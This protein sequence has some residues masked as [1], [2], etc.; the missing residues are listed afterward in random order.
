MNVQ[1]A[2]A[3]P[4]AE[5]L[6]KYGHEPVQRR[7]GDL[8]YRSPFR[9][10]E[11]ASFVVSTQ[12]NVWF[13]HGEGK[14]GTVID[15]IARL[16]NETSVAKVLALVSEMVE[17]IVPE[18][19]REIRVPDGKEG[20]KSRTIGE[21][22]LS[23]PALL[24]YLITRA[25]PPEFARRYVREIRY[26]ISGKAYFGIG[27]RNQGGGFEVRNPY[28]K[29]CV[30]TKDI[31]VIGEGTGGIVNVFEGFMDFL[32]WPLLAGKAEHTETAVVL[33]SVSIVDRAIARLRENPPE[34]IRL[35]LDND[36]AG[37]AAVERIRAALPETRVVDMADRYRDSEDVNQELVRRRDRKAELEK[38]MGKGNEN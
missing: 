29:G 35:F 32:S 36:T 30:G 33:N 20:A 26:E 25:I 10:E 16:S 31:S 1:K 4:L 11:T 17:G 8:W 19:H 3:I 37:R 27:F 23:H 22:E 18:V 2:K 15:L 38:A 5:I 34:E 14:G 12:K 7:G 9:A 13:D 6:Q 24:K 28:F 21:K